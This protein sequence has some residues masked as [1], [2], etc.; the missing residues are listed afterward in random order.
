MP[1]SHFTAPLGRA[2]PSVQTTPQ[3]S[4][5]ALLAAALDPCRCN[6]T[7]EKKKNNQPVTAEIKEFYQQVSAEQVCASTDFLSSQ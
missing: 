5:R 6:K 7:K 2:F 4:A 3:S 1:L